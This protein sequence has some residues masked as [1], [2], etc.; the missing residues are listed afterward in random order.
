MSEVAESFVEPILG[1]ASL[2]V[3]RICYL[4]EEFAVRPVGPCTYQLAGFCVPSWDFVTH[5]VSVGLN[6][7]T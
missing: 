1:A 5:D 2:V 6:S 7:P 3:P 4:L